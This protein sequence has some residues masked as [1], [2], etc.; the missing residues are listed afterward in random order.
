MLIP[1]LKAQGPRIHLRPIHHDDAKGPYLEWINDSEVTRFLVSRLPPQRVEDLEAYIQQANDK[2]DD[3]L[4]AA[5][6]NESG[7]HIGNL[8]LQHIDK[9][10]ES[11]WLSIVIGHKSTWGKGIGTEAVALMTK[12]G[13]EHLNLRRIDAGCY[14]ENKPAIKTFLNCGYTQEGHSREQFCAEGRTWDA[15]WLGILAIDAPLWRDRLG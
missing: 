10:H 12:V 9:T 1:D 11:A 8:K 13:L 15:V 6:D 2:A 4:L 5:C 3:L 14:A 7:T